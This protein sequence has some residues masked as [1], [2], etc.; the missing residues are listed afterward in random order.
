MTRIE[1]PGAISRVTHCA[2]QRFS[3]VAVPR[4]DSTYNRRRVR[5]KPR[6]DQT[7][8][9]VRHPDLGNCVGVGR[10]FFRL[11]EKQTSHPTVAI[12]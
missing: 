11:T 3:R 9:C 12:A 8:V 1:W 4:V 6:D 10:S 5:K 7:D 2:E